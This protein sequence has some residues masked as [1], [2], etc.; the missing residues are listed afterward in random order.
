MQQW[1]KTT[2]TNN[3]VQVTIFIEKSND[4]L[5]EHAYTVPVFF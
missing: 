3:F 1:H 4:F 5:F 2:N